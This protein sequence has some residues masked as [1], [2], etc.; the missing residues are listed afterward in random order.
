MKNKQKIQQMLS[1][2]FIAGTQ[3]CQHLSGDPARN[4]LDILQQALQA[5]ITCF[6]FRDKGKNSLENQPDQQKQLAKQCLSLC[7]QYHVPLIINDDMAL[8]MEIGADGIHVGQ[9]DMTISQVLKQTE[10]K[11]IIGLSTNNLAQILAAQ[12]QAD[13]DYI[14]V[15]PIFPTPSKSDHSPALGIEFLSRLKHEQL[16][17][18]FVVIG[19]VNQYNAS[20]LK[21]LGADGVAVIS[22]ITQAENIADVVEKLK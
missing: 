14:G 1:V 3:D 20:Q 21:Q 13:I 18:P 12:Q 4:L 22:A 2:Y 15:G 8:A 5:G 16:N 10:H 9:S 17:K 6:Q 11:L 19:G 7:H